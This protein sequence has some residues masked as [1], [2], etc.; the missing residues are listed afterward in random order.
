MKKIYV[1]IAVFITVLLGITYYFHQEKV[2]KA[3][4]VV[5]QQNRAAEA[6]FMAR[7]DTTFKQF[8]N[9]FPNYG[10]V[11]EDYF[12]ES[13]AK[14]QSD[15]TLSTLVFFS[16]IPLTKVEESYFRCLTQ[17]AEFEVGKLKI[18]EQL[19]SN[20][21]TLKRR[22]GKD[23]DFWMEKVGR[24]T[25]LNTTQGTGYCNKFFTTFQELSINQTALGEFQD[26]LAKYRTDK[27]E[28]KSAVSQYE[29]EFLRDLSSVRNS[30]NNDGQRYLNNNLDRDEIIEST[31][32]EYAFEGEIIGSYEYTF[33]TKVYHRETLKTLTDQ[34]IKEQ[35]KN[36]SLAHGSKPYSYCFGS[37]NSC[38]G[39]NC[40]QLE[41]QASYSSDVLVTLKSEGRV[42]R[43][44]Y[45]TAGR[46][47][48]FDVPN[49]RY[50]P[51]FYSGSGWN[52]NKVMKETTCGTL[53]GGFV[54]GGHVGKDSPQY[55][56]NQILTYELIEQIDGN[57]QT[58]P[59]STNEAF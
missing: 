5:E 58:R 10:N 3:K 30:L 9:K 57:F 41:V 42:V 44:A 52:P 26:L 54:S 14:G 22:Y 19:N 25:F 50:Q 31:N 11:I 23:V 53:R 21:N 20:L 45:I 37:Y 43:H 51:F 8:E 15:T 35:Y 33:P 56:S 39:Y 28:S 29:Q 46:T 38:D 49:G 16:N 13:D 6:N 32:R 59:S 17:K 27:S 48:T 1:A 34:A 47:Y 55:L 7:R 2:E 12:S 40:S 24:E 4:L 36:N 18:E